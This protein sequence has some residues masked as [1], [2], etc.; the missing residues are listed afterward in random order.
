MGSEM[1]IRDRTE[2]AKIIGHNILFGT[3]VILA[4]IFA[5][6]KPNIKNKIF[7]ISMAPKI[8]KEILAVL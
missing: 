2:T 8:P 1:C 5:P 3:K 4:K 7:A 6:K